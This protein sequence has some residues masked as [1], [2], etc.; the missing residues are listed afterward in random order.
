MPPPKWGIA[1][2]RRFDGLE[3]L[4]ERR[5][6]PRASLPRPVRGV[7]NPAATTSRSSANAPS[8]EPDDGYP[9]PAPVCFGTRK[10]G[11]V[12]RTRELLAESVTQRSGAVAVK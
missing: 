5:Q 7:A 2:S 8:R 6:R 1:T 3:V 11:D 9:F 12:S 4:A 10:L